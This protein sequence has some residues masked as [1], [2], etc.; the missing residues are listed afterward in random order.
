MLLEKMKKWYTKVLLE[1]NDK[2]N[3]KKKIMHKNAAGKKW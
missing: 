2:K 1:K 3:D